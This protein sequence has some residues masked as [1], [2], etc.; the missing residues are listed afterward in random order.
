MFAPLPPPGFFASF[1]NTTI[2]L[3][4]LLFVSRHLPH[5]PHLPYIASSPSLPHI[6]ALTSRRRQAETTAA[7]APAANRDSAGGPSPAVIVGGVVVGSVALSYPFFKRWGIPPAATHLYFSQL[8]RPADPICVSILAPSLIDDAPS[9][10]ALSPVVYPPPLRTF[11]RLFILFCS[12][13]LPL[14][15]WLCIC[16]G[17]FEIFGGR[18]RAERND[19]SLT[20]H[21]VECAGVWSAWPRRPRARG[22]GNVLVLAAAYWYGA[23]CEPTLL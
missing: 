15:T 10:S 12:L 6:F 23:G 22:R 13:P 19:W 4:P 3:L 17:G 2:L 21:L 9:L 20:R 14:F 8:W 11:P 1:F 16:S 5:L 18:G 7:P